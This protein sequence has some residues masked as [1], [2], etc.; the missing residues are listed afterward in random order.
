MKKLA[1]RL[2]DARAFRHSLSSFIRAE[3]DGL[4]GIVQ[5]D[6]G[7]LS[8][9]RD[10]GQ[11]LANRSVVVKP[12]AARLRH[13]SEV[14]LLTRS[15]SDIVLSI[16]HMSV[17]RLIGTERP[18]REFSV[19]HVLTKTYQS[20]RVRAETAG[21]GS[22]G[23]TRPDEQGLGIGSGEVRNVGGTAACAG[24]SDVNEGA[25]GGAVP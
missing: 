23:A 15:L 20:V 8:T 18:D 7:R 24:P 17:N 14:P 1:K 11:I 12:R 13:L 10:V 22:E 16:V 6:Y 3:R 2:Q 4:R 21:V 19:Y 25:T 5:G 9:A